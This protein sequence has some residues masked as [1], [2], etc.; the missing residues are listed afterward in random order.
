MNGLAIGF[1]RV[2][3]WVT[4]LAY[5]NLL[6]IAFTLVGLIVFGFAPATAAMFAVVRKWVSG[7]DD[8]PIFKTFWKVYRKEFWKIFGVG[9][10]LAVVGYFIYIEFSILRTQDSLM[11]YLASFGVIGQYILYF[12]VVMYFF[13]IYAHFDLKPFAYLK[14]AFAIGVSHPILTLFLAVVTNVLLYVTAV[15]LPILIVF[16]GGSVTAYILTWGASKTFSAY[17]RVY[18]L[19]V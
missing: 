6:W 8:I 1:Y 2:A 19:N 5:V 17:E 13:P 15:T 12:I 4:R 18:E 7:E 11:Y 14:W 3:E 16:F 10:I 9:F